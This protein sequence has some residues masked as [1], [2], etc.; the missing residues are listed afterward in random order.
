MQPFIKKLGYL[1][2]T[3]MYDLVHDVALYHEL[4]L[5]VSPVRLETDEHHQIGALTFGFKG[6]EQRVVT[7]NILEAPHA[8]QVTLH[9]GPFDHLAGHWYFE[10]LEGGGC[11]IKL[12]FAFQLSSQWLSALFLPVFLKVSNEL[13]ATFCQRADKKYGS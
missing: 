11:H 7:R 4:C 8:I 13:V 3:S 12:D 6:I 5:I 1:P 10:A 9:S 2:A